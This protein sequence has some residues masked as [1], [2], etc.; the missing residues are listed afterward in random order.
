MLSGFDSGGHL[1]GD[2]DLESLHDD[3]RFETLL[4][5]VDELDDDNDFRIKRHKVKKEKKSTMVS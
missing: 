5:R 4:E 2:D 1:A 3:P